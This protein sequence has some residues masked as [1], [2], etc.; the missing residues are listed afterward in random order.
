[1]LEGAKPR[2]IH[3]L[4]RDRKLR[5]SK[6]NICTHLAT[7]ELPFGS[8]EESPLDVEVT[9]PLFTLYQLSLGLHPVHALMA[10]YEFCGS[11]TVFRPAPA[12]E[13][14]VEQAREASF[15]LRSPWKCVKDNAGR[16]TDLWRRPPLVEVGELQ[17]FAG[18]L[19]D[20]RGG[21]RFKR[22][23]SLVTGET[24]SPFEA[25]LSILLALPRRHGGE[26]LCGQF[27]NNERIALTSRASRLAGR[28]AC[29]ADVLFGEPEGGRPL[30]VECQGKMVHG[31][32]EALMSDSDRTVA[33]QQMGYNVLPLTYGQIANANNFDTVRR[34]I[35]KELGLRYR[36]RSPL[37]RDAEFEL[38]RNLFIDWGTLGC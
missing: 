36:D 33:L 23:A 31:R 35:F 22:L 2:A 26:G 27:S 20:R 19:D 9:S 38:R 4:V 37:Q 13:P 24:A 8:I 6:P 11:F 7:G 28:R 10:M 15:D 17:R 14:Y 16:L 32:A 3:L 1:M 29:Y 30:V 18:S 12:L 25:Q 34:H 5:R 21:K